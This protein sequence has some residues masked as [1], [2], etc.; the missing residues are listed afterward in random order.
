MRLVDQV[1]NPGSEAM[2]SAVI[3]DPL[4][5]CVHELFETQAALTPDACAVRIGERHVTYRELN[6]RANQLA[7]HLLQSAPDSSRPVAIMMDRGLT[8]LVSILAVLKTG[9]GYVPLDLSLPRA[10]IDYILAD[11]DANCLLVDDAARA[12]LGDISRRCILVDTD[13]PALHAH[14]PHN[15]DVPVAPLDQAYSIYT[16]GSTGRPKGVMIQHR[17]LANY[18]WWARNRYAGDDIRTFAFYSSISFDLTVTSIF[19]PLVCGREVIIYSDTVGEIPL[20]VRVV[21]D[22]QVDFLKLTP[23]HL[24]VIRNC[25]LEHSRLKVLVLGGEDLLAAHAADIYHKLGQRTRIFNEYGPTEATVGCMIHTFDPLRDTVGSVP[26]GVSIDHMKVHLLDEQMHPVD[27]GDVGEIYI[28]GPGVALGYRNQPE[29]TARSFVPSPFGS[30]MPRY[31]SGDLAR[32][33]ARGDM[34][35]LGRKDDQ[36]KLRGYRIELGEVENALLAVPGVQRCTVVSTKSA[37]YDQEAKERFCVRCG[38]SSNYPNTVFAATGECNHCQAFESYRPVIETFFTDENE[39]DS[40]IDDMKGK[41]HQTYDCIVAFSGGK[42]STYAL[43]RLV[44]KGVRVLAFTLDNG[45]ISEDAKQNINRV[46]TALRI[47][48]RYLHTE[49]MNEIFVDSLRRYSNVCNGCFKTIYTFAV[50]LAR[51]V[52]VDHIVTGLSR[53]Q[54]LETRLGELL[55]EP[56][57]D[58][59]SFER[60]V[61]EA[62]KIYHR[63]DDAP[64]RRLD[65]RCVRD[66]AVMDRIR[67]VDFYRYCKVEREAMYAYICKRVGWSRPLDTGRSTNCLINDVGIY[68]HNKE[69]RFHNYS[70]PYSWDVRL[71]HIDREAALRELDDATDVDEARV[72]AILDD[73]GYQPNETLVE[74]SEAQ[75]VAYYVAE[76]GIEQDTLRT[77]L[78]KILPDY[79]VPTTFVQIDQIPLTPNGKVNRQALPAPDARKRSVA[80]ADGPRDDIER[81]LVELW[82]EILLVENIGIHDDFFALG[83]HSLPALMLLYRVDGKFGKTIGIQQFSTA[84]T[85]EGLARQIRSEP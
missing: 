82:K 33:D 70:L 38:I 51:E 20:V 65:T 26:I 73:V 3:S 75:L 25:D 69:R 55:R 19:V 15:L 9:V 57:F 54:L 10:R 39:M 7:R 67:F 17:A 22:N 60:N 1:R 53:G 47:G 66:D 41:N 56:V 31:A 81:D 37:R 8:C 84:P 16:S 5:T 49:H 2:A 4:Q 6:V 68:V 72:K 71:G 12:R 63:I 58:A 76:E 43:C 21:E 85:I 61:I 52:G 59:P 44:D 79:M 64:G 83:G 29:L 46:V 77:E 80:P 50:N 36:V 45:Y 78:S 34:I 32:V 35:F 23:A 48:H 11:S 14:A 74:A 13:D 62:R 27:A 24:A 30:G 18:V 42:D 28:E 40:I